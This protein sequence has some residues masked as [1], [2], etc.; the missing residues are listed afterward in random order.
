MHYRL[1]FTSM[2]SPLYW[3]ICSIIN[4]IIDRIVVGSWNSNMQWLIKVITWEKCN[5]NALNLARPYKI[6]NCTQKKTRLYIYIYISLILSFFENII[7]HTITKVPNFLQYLKTIIIS[8]IFKFRYL[9]QCLVHSK[10]L[11][12]NEK[13]NLKYGKYFYLFIHERNF[14]NLSYEFMSGPL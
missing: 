13:C 5:D 10:I 12:I 9:S 7:K 11:E 2:S 1:T 14:I 4:D 3:N 6:R 8:F